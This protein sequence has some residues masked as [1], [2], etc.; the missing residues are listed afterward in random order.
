MTYLDLI[1]SKGDIRQ[2]ALRAADPGKTLC[3]LDATGQS[4]PAEPGYGRGNASCGNCDR[5]ERLAAAKT[6]PPPSQ[7]G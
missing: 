2:H 5:L 4:Q 6:T 3:G 7:E 1:D